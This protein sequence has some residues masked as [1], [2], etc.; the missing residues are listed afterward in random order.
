MALDREF[1]DSINIE[2]VKKK[3]YNAN[4]VRA[5]LDDI[6]AQAEAL[7]AENARL[8]EE[9]D[10]FTGKRTEIGDA[11]LTAQ[12]AAKN[13]IDKA[14]IDAARIIQQAQ[15]NGGNIGL[16]SQEHAV[17][18]VE[19]CFTELKR[20]QMDNIETLNNRW[21]EFLCGLIPDGG[22]AQKAS[23]LSMGSAAA[24]AAQSAPIE[25]EKA[26]QSDNRIP[27]DLEN[28]VSAIAKELREII[29]RD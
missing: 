17:E 14:N 3:Y 4:K 19:R 18:C 9:L 28:R 26:G 7:N 10:S 27:Q 2:V 16:A 29:D 5:L 6:Q 12:A 22:K 23:A 15:E 25:T 8:R 20:Q 1:F 21:Q 11:M 24:K 13:I